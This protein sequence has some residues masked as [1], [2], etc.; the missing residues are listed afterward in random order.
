MNFKLQYSLFL[1]LWWISAN[2]YSQDYDS[3]FNKARF[4]YENDEYQ[5]AIPYFSKYIKYNSNDYMAYKLRGNCFLETGQNTL[6]IQDY[7]TAAKIK[8][9]SDLYYNLGI[10]YE[11]MGKT[12]S[13]IYYF[14]FFTNMEPILAEGYIRL[15]ILF[16]YGHPEWGDSAIYYASRAVN[17]EPENPGILNFLA[18]AY[19]SDS[20]YKKAL[21]SSLAGLRIDSSHSLL[22]RSA[23]I[24]SFF[25]K[26]Y[27]SA[28]AYFDRAFSNNPKDFTILD[29]KIQSLLLQNTVPE[30]IIFLPG[31]RIS[32]HNFTSEKIKKDEQ[33]I[34]KKTGRYEYKMLKQKLQT[35][36]LSMSLDEFFMLYIG[37]ALQPGYSP[38][39][40]PG[41]KKTTENN[42]LKEVI[43]LEE[44]LLNDP[45]GFTDYLILADIYLEMGNEKKYFEN[46][47]KYFGFAESIKAA[48][49]GLTAATAYI[50]NDI[51]HEQRIMESL[52]Y[53]IK[54]QSRIEKKKHNYD[55]LTGTDQ[56]NTEVR[57]YFNI[58]RPLST[59]PKK[60]KH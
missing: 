37:Y 60:G 1:A 22:N 54:G 26:D 48:G 34:L 47:F 7:T 52:G 9:D 50:V 46:R 41:P 39:Y 14:R 6:A 30:Q 19:Y 17:I 40:K 15:C 51:S 31:S 4:Y 59:L 16:M 58:D 57:I 36:A 3:I 38:F 53:R 12:D 24:C 32:L 23:G 13:S 44:I 42:L 49:D 11:K 27:A 29:Y 33:E 56:N 5:M 35:S 25:L 18:T 55:I 8:K 10:A 2:I 43:D 45:T 21:E 28:I 20:Q